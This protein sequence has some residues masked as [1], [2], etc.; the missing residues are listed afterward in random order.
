M[1][2]MSFAQNMEDVMLWRALKHVENGF[3][4]DIGAF[5]P[6]MESVTRAFY[7]RNWR[8]VNV[9]PNPHFQTALQERRPRDVNL[10]LAV[11]DTEGAIALHIVGDTGLSSTDAAI[12]ADHEKAGWHTSVIQVP[13]LRLSSIWD[14]HVPINQPVHFL[15]VDVEGHEAAVLKSADWGR[16]RPWIVVVEATL[17]NSQIEA[18][19]DW[20]PTLTAARYGFVYE[21]GL[22]RF[23]V[24]QEHPE[25]IG[26]F[27][28]P[29]NH[30]DAYVQ[31]GQFNHF[32]SGRPPEK[33]IFDLQDELAHE[34]ARA[35]AATLE[36]TRLR[37]V[38][39]LPKGGIGTD[40]Q[41]IAYLTGR[42]LWERL[43][44][45]PNGR[46]IKPLRRLLF[47]KNGKPRGIFR[48]L[49]LHEDGRPHKPFLMWMS[50]SDYRALPRPAG[51]VT[52]PGPT[53]AIDPMLDIGADLTRHGR[54]MLDRLELVRVQDGKP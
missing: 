21:D 1:P 36:N 53:P 7:E 12:V 48:G 25:L 4:I 24:A 14:A 20:E 17:P 32:Q 22:N 18:H 16:H 39:R 9:E 35:D 44:F 52:G 41:T 27:R 13:A 43:L 15:K 8:G 46:P 31:Q 6:D 50:S 47:H 10:Q 37:A 54:A 49:V 42:S 34:R 29:P 26:A 45:R 2:F 23:Y 38:L 5:S 51:Q 11:S 3:Y 19:A 28:Y 33:S 30:F 40:E